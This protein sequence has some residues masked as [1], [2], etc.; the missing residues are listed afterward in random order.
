MSAAITRD[1]ISQNGDY[2][3]QQFER[4]IYLS[5]SGSLSNLHCTVAFTA[6]KI[7]RSKPQGQFS[8]DP[9]PGAQ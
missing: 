7:L 2:V 5:A 8:A 1:A 3:W 9:I 6:L 4:L